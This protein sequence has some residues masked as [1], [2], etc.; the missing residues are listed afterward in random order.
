M[1][2]CAPELPLDIVA[3][4]GVNSANTFIADDKVEESALTDSGIV[5]V[6]LKM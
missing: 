3:D 4:T 1:T 6:V 5:A 2:D